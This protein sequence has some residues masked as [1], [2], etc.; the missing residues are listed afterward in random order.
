MSISLFYR[1]MNTIL[2]CTHSNLDSEDSIMDQRCLPFPPAHFVPKFLEFLVKRSRNFRR[3]FICQK[4]ISICLGSA[5]LSWSI[6][7]MWI[8][9]TIHRI[10]KYLYLAIFSLKSGLMTLITHLKIIL[11]QYFQFSVLVF[12]NKQYPNRLLISNVEIMSSCHGH[13]THPS[14][15]FFF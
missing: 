6:F 3:L 14:F 1:S 9:Y 5:F 7:F 4:C 10:Y 13:N 15:I 11:L 12:S 2:I 8:R